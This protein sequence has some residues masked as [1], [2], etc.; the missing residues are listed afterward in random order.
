MSNVAGPVFRDIYFTSVTDKDWVLETLSTSLFP[1]QCVACL[2]MT[3]SLIGV[4]YF[5]VNLNYPSIL[6]RWVLCLDFG[7]GIFYIIRFAPNS[8]QYNCR[9]QVAIESFFQFGSMYINTC[10]L[11]SLFQ[12]MYGMQKN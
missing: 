9:I 5:K 6:Y 12:A 10:I 1:L 8:P 7:Y 3:A 11:Q 4:F 2:F